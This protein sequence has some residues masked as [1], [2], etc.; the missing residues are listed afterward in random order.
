MFTNDGPPA[1]WL[2]PLFLFNSPAQSAATHVLFELA[3]TP[4]SVVCGTCTLSAARSVILYPW[5]VFDFPVYSIPTLNVAFVW[6]NERHRDVKAASL[7]LELFFHLSSEFRQFQA[8]NKIER[9]AGNSV[10]VSSDKWFAAELH[11]S[12]VYLHVSPCCLP[13]P[14]LRYVSPAAMNRI[15]AVSVAACRPTHSGGEIEHVGRALLLEG[16]PLLPGY[17]P[18]PHLSNSDRQCL[19]IQPSQEISIRVGICRNPAPTEP[20]TKQ[21]ESA[22]T[23]GS[24]TKAYLL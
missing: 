2:P 7:P 10:N 18:F 15:P 14:A 20:A 17:S 3:A 6:A 9:P 11:Y 4:S 13:S 1:S 12:V 23:G 8:H 22:E 19:R 5:F 16:P 24:R 21:R